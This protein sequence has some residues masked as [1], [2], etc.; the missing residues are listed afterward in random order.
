MENLMM[1]M[2]TNENLKFYAVLNAMGARITQ[3]SER[4]FHIEGVVRLSGVTHRVI[5]DRLE[6]ASFASAALLRAALATPNW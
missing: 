4:A 2:F 5:P 3:T 6:A 1:F